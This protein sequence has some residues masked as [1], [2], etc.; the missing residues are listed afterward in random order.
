MLPFVPGDRLIVVRGKYRGQY[1]TY[2]GKYGIVM[3]S[4]KL[5]G[6]TIEKH[7]RLTSVSLVTH[8]NSNH[9]N[10]TTAEHDKEMLLMKVKAKITAMKAELEVLEDLM[11]ELT[12]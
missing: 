9:G 3:C 5:D 10:K 4:V 1:A 2:I 6:D 8:T 7:L 12:L 11:N